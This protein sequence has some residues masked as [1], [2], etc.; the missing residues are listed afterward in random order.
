[1]AIYFKCKYCEHHLSAWVV[2]NS[3]RCDLCGKD[4]KKNLIVG[5][6]KEW[7]YVGDRWNYHT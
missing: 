3:D 1:M 4:L 2:E 7:D 6:T 5:S